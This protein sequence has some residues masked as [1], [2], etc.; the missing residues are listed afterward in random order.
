MDEVNPR[1]NKWF[2]RY[3]T[4]KARGCCSP[5]PRISM[6]KIWGVVIYHSGVLIEFMFLIN[7]SAMVVPG[8]EGRSM[9]AR[10][11]IKLNRRIKICASTI[12]GIINECYQSYHT[13]QLQRV[14]KNFRTILKLTENNYNGLWIM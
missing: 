13:K 3:A 8:R 7:N 11:S 14:Y 12:V 2:L 10:N 1:G 9:A 4:I 5:R 6:K